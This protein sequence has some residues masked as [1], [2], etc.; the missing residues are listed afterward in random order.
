MRAK[1]ASPT[2]YEVSNGSWMV[3][4]KEIKMIICAICGKEIKMEDALVQSDTGAFLCSD[5]CM[6][7]FLANC[8]GFFGD[9]Y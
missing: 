6:S 3:I 5:D 8:D 9:E 2:P 7:E 4:V 1:G